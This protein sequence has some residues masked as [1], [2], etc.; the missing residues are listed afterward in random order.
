MIKVYDKAQ[1]HIDAGEESSF[2]VAKF[3][4]IFQFLDSKD[5]LSDE[6]KEIMEVG[7][8]SSISLHERMVTDKG[9]DFLEVCYDRIIN[10]RTDEITDALNI[11]FDHYIDIYFHKEQ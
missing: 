11:E 5:L 7:I 1:W 8:D 2:V 9:R 10:I 6:G 4:A 3:K